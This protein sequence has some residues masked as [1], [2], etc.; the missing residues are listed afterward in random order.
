MIIGSRLGPMKE[1]MMDASALVCNREV[2][3][4]IEICETCC[5]VVPLEVEYASARRRQE[6]FAV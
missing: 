3:R 2:S 6:R 4:S 1:V 5:E